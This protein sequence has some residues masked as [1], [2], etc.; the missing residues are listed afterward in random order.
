MDSGFISTQYSCTFKLYGFNIPINF[1][2]C[3]S[4]KALGVPHQYKSS[5][6]YDFQ[7]E[8]ILLAIFVNIDHFVCDHNKPYKN[9]NS[10]K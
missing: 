5:L 2:N 4:F 6:N 1:S 7:F 9:H 10:D 8:T 3:S